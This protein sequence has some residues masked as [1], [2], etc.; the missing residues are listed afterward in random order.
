MSSVSWLLPRLLAT[1]L[2]SQFAFA[3]QAAPAQTASATEPAPRPAISLTERGD[4]YMARKMY[5]EAVEAYKQ[6]PPSPLMLNKIGIAYHQMTDLDSARKYYER[7]I[8]MDPKYAEAINNLGTIYYARKSYRRAIGEY[9][10]ALRLS[11]DSAS[12]WANLGSAYFARKNFELASEAYQHALTLDPEVFERHSTS[13]STVQERSVGDRA[14]F[15]YYLAKSYAKAGRNDQ[16]I[17]YIRKAL[18]EGFKE[19]EKFTQEPE[20]A[21]LRDEPEFKELMATE[22]KVL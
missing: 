7:A 3:F 5:R 17:I 18:E 16:A 4:I 10:K 15:H 21:G 6:V 22:P 20:F 19:R 12:A 11:E 2:A 13:G 9:K 1:G 8:K 14:K